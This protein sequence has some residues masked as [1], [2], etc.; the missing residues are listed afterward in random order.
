ML[1][2]LSYC[3]LQVL[4]GLVLCAKTLVVTLDST[5]YHNSRRHTLGVSTDPPG[6][7][8]TYVQEALHHWHNGDQA[9]CICP[10]HPSNAPEEQEETPTPISVSNKRKEANTI[11]QTSVH[12]HWWTEIIW[13]KDEECYYTN[14]LL[15]K[16]HDY[17][18]TDSKEESQN[19]EI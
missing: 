3:L 12:P 11:Q 4:L 17:N 8:Q 18:K 7:N 13:N 5:C 10:V 1:L 16:L 14:G 9:Q 15:K 6:T 2:S 19:S